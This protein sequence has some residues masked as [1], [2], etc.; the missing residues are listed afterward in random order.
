MS[1]W[2]IY[3]QFGLKCVWNWTSWA[4]RNNFFC[5]HRIL[6]IHQKLF[7][8]LA[9]S[10]FK[11]S[12]TNKANAFKSFITKIFI[13]FI[14][15]GG[16]FTYLYFCNKA[17]KKALFQI[18]WNEEKKIIHV[19]KSE[20]IKHKKITSGL[21]DVEEGNKKLFF[22]IS[23]SFFSCSAFPSTRRI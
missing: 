20:N 6:Q 3:I 14:P 1:V 22:Y 16:L 4:T 5:E 12:E 8:Y 21:K 13:T 23:F 11:H 18:K 9:K 7:N 2:W 19:R 15:L 17:F 10:Y